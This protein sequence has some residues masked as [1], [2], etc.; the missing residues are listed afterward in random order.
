PARGVVPGAGGTGG[1]GADG[2]RGSTV[3]A[4]PSGERARQSPHRAGV[5]PGR[6]REP[7][8]RTAPGGGDLQLLAPAGASGRGPVVARS[9]ASTGGRSVLAGPS[10]G[11]H[12]RGF[13]R[14]GPRGRCRGALPC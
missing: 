6:R 11:P 5:E 13:P 14:V 9:V 8:G 1:A 10:A 4:R 7:R 2:R 3:M 12:R